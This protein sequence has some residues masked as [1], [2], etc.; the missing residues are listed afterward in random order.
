MP[1]RA[2]I[3]LLLE[4]SRQFTREIFHGMIRWSHIYGPVS[5]ITTTGGHIRRSIPQLNSTKNIGLIARLTTPGVVDAVRRMKIPLVTIEPSVE[6]YVR[7][8]QRLQVSEI[9]SNSPAIAQLGFQH[10]RSRG[11]RHFGFCGLP[12]RI[13][14]SNRQESFVQYVQEA[15]FSCFVYPIP[16]SKWN[17]SPEKERPLLASWLRLL[18]KPIAI[19][20]C[21]DDRGAQLIDI[22]RENEILVP[23]EIA[24]LGVDNDELLCELSNPQLSSV[25]LDLENVGFQAMDLLWKM[26]SGSQS[27]YHRIPLDPLRIITRNSSDVVSQDDDI[28]NRAMRFIRTSYQIPIGV[29]EVAREL[30]ISRRTLERH[31]SDVL[32]C[33]VWEQIQIFRL[34]QA[35]RLLE[36]TDDTVERIAQLSG[37]QNLKPMLR[38]FQMREGGTPSEYRKKNKEQRSENI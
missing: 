8:K 6:K 20:C 25:K 27:G 4:M 33:S 13:W 38:F 2:T 36:E 15:G 1:Q 14:S 26:I 22:C 30:D 17:T 18:P 28:V 37:F 7:I 19:M 35:K 24:I 12:Q 16:Q 21:N 9:V 23:D 32:R 3:Y 34:E 29:N 31:F 10:F 5:F 11:F